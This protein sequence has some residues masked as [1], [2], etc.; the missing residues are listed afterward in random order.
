MSTASRGRALEH[1]AKKMLEADGWS[2]MRG[3]GSKGHFDSVDGKVKPDLI[4][5]KKKRSNKYILQ[6]MLIQAKVQGTR[7]KATKKNTEAEGVE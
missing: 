1:E 7:G 5:T 4:A 2:V 6:I 3:A